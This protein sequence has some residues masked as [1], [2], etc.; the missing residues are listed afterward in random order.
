MKIRIRTTFSIQVSPTELRTYPKGEYKIPTDKF[1]LLFSKK[2]RPRKR[3]H[4][5]AVLYVQRNRRIRI[6]QRGNGYEAWM[7]I[8]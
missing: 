7:L 6:A 3:V 4:I 1:L 5:R 8:D 2:H